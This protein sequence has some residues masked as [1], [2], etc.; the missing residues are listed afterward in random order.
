[1]GD[2]QIGYHKVFDM[3]A[4]GTMLTSS[5]SRNAPAI[6][7][8]TISIAAGGRPPALWSNMVEVVW[9]LVCCLSSIGLS[10]VVHSFP[11][12]AHKTGH[13]FPAF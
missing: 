9:I 5:L 13:S 1:M 6:S 11:Y 7:S 2:G 4:P 10:F 3:T 12:V 8:L